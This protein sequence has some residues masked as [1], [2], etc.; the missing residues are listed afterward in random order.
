MKLTFRVYFLVILCFCI[1]NGF[2]QTIPV[3]E[4]EVRAELEKRG[5]A[6]EDLIREMNARGIEIDDLENLSPSQLAELE[7]IVQQLEAEKKTTE[8]TPD[9]IVDKESYLDEPTTKETETVKQE[10]QQ[11]I[12]EEGNVK[13]PDVNIYGHSFFKNRDLSVFETSTEVKAPDSYILGAGDKIV[14]SIYGISR[15]ELAHEINSEGAIEVNN[16]RIFLKGISLGQAKKKLF[17]ALSRSY[18]FKQ[19]EFDVALSYSRTINV[20]IQG[21]VV[22]PGGYT[23]SAINN[24]F[25]GLIAAGGPTSIGSLRDILL[26]KK[27]GNIVNLDFYSFLQNP[28]ASTNAFL[29]E[30]DVIVIPVARKIVQINGGVKRPMRYEMKEKEKLTDLI[31][32]AG[33][34]RSNAN[35]S[36]I[37][38]LRYNVGGKEY[39][40]VREQ[41]IQNFDLKDG[42]LFTVNI[43]DNEVDNFVNIGGAVIND[44]NY[45][46]VEGMLLKDL[47]SL[48][49]LKPG[50]RKDFG[51]IRRM[52]EDGKVVYIKINIEAGSQDLN[53]PLI[54]KDQI[55]IYNQ[56]TFND[57]QEFQ[58]S[59][60][61]RNSGSFSLSIDQQLSIKNAI[62]IAGGLRRDA[63][64]IGI[65]HTVDPL[66]PK[67]K[68]YRRI[69]ILEAFE[70]EDAFSIGALDSLEIFSKNLFDERSEVRV[71]GAVNRPGSYQF[72]ESMT[73]ADVLTM[74]GGFKLGAATNRIEISR[75]VIENNEPT[76]TIIANFK[77]DRDLKENSENL[78]FVLEPYDEII[79][80]YVP[81]FEMQNFVE[82]EG[83]VKFPG[84]YSLIKDNETIKD[85]VLRAGGLTMEAFPAGAKLVRSD[86][87]LG[88]V[89]VKL[90]EV[91]NSNNSKFNFKLKNGD[92]IVIPKSK[93]FVSI[94]GATNANKLYVQDILGDQNMLNVPFHKGKDAKFYIE[95]YAGGINDNGSRN[96][97]FVENPNGEIKRTRNYFVYKNY[98]EVLVGSKI[99]V[100]TKPAKTKEQKDREDVDWSKVLADSVGQ[101]VSI[102]SLLLLIQRL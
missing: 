45:E 71:S 100:G 26:I 46:R 81:E 68:Q 11:I 49:T 15:Q 94:V 1:S 35:R 48:G 59:G 7:Q 99:V 23:I 39:V 19:G 80:R 9:T 64:G 24:A 47:I 50:A 44:G 21:E 54:N 12:K 69:N 38:L 101:A 30:G 95:T 74:S 97:I 60:A 28:S 70:N 93:D 33:G 86:D 52:Q 92:R 8:V 66:N 27:D 5:I 20:N 56:S 37:Q 85:V 79:V 13:Q 62:E 3:T 18:R 6:E 42:D 57:N 63:S 36:L 41:E 73:L 34:Y 25:N 91:L 51:Y 31:N 22:S 90:D 78:D 32:L 98:P 17:N 76:K 87:G 16:Q 96:E 10:I 67:V 55:I 61:V 75:L 29:E 89:I 40:D 77:I 83:E 65:I 82:I 102:L 43:I 72:G 2:A 88:V 14:I 4:S 58:V 53:I 84:Q